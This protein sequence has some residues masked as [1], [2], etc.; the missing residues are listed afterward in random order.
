M[1]KNRA[2]SLLLGVLMCSSA[3]AA[4]V[5]TPKVKVADQHA[6]IDLETMV[7]RAFGDW[8]VDPNA[9]GNVLPSPDAQATLEKIYDQIL[10]RTYVN[11]RGE[12]MMLTI[13]YGSAQTQE[14]KA[15]RQEVCYAAQGFEIQGLEHPTL[16]I[17][18]RQVPVTRMFAAKGERKEPVTYWFT[19]GDQVVLSRTERLLVQVKYAFSGVIPDGMLVRVSN[20]KRNPQQGYEEQ[21][22]F[23]DQMMST[24]NKDATDKLLG[25]DGHRPDIR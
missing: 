8:Q 3:L 5:L 25:I 6:R 14:L 1:N 2:I 21:R 22:V 7:P 20:L 23:L 15:H 24:L 4:Y 19:M 12:A 10:T 17:A 13:T 11:S 9:G 18:G 16:P